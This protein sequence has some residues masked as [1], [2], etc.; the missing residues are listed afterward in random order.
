MNNQILTNRDISDKYKDYQ[1][2][3]MISTFKGAFSYWTASQNPN[4]ILDNN[5]ALIAY[6]DYLKLR[7]FKDINEPVKF[8]CDKL[9]SIV[10]EDIFSAIPEVLALNEMQP[11][12]ID[13]GALAKNVYYMILRES[14][15]QD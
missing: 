15:T 5:D 11:D 7:V 8:T 9:K 10:N 3:A 12:F 2:Y 13:L 6:I 1:F 14:I 4:D